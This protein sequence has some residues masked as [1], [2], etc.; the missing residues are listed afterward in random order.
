MSGD[1]NFHCHMVNASKEGLQTKTK[2][3]F[4]CGYMSVRGSTEASH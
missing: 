1:P 3:L 4:T 2:I